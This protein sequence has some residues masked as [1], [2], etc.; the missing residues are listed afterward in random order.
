MSGPSSLPALSQCKSKHTIKDKLTGQVLGFAFLVDDQSVSSEQI[1]LV[2]W[3]VGALKPQDDGHG[4]DQALL[5]PFPSLNA[6]DA[7]SINIVSDLDLSDDSSTNETI[8]NDVSQTTD[9]VE[10]NQG[11]QR[12][13]TPSNSK[14][15]S[16]DNNIQSSRF[17]PISSPPTKVINIQSPI[18]VAPQ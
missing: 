5:R 7:P 13:N 2:P 16:L 8:E 6:G 14:S 9:D 18:L 12:P 1:Q 3:H 11:N 10:N 15:S 4:G 17:I